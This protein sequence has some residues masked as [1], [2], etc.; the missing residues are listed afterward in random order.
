MVDFIKIYGWLGPEKQSTSAKSRDTIVEFLMKYPST[1]DGYALQHTLRSDSDLI[2]DDN[3]IIS[4]IETIEPLVGKL[5]D[6]LKKRR[7][8]NRSAT[9]LPVRSPR[10]GV[11]HS[12]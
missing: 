6:K 2:R 3:M 7:L 11:G 1:A 12:M 4:G 10:Y 5:R 8:P 9:R